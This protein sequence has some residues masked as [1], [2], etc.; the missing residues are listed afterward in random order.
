MAPSGAP[1]SRG[2]VSEARGQ[3]KV[4]SEVRRLVDEWRGFELGRASE[5]YP[6][7]PPRYD[8]VKEGESRLTE[9]TLSLLLHWFRHEPHMVG[10][11]PNTFAFKY[12]PH[13][14]RLVETF[15]YLHEVRGIRRTE[16][17]YQLAGVDPM[18]PQRDPWAKLGGQLAT[19]SGKTKMMSL[20]IAWAYLNAVGERDS[21]LGFG[22]H[23]ILIAPGLFV[24]DRLLMDFAP[25]NK[26]PSVFFADPV[27]PP[28]F[29]SVWNLK[30]YSPETCPRTLDPAEGAL[31]VTNYHQLLRK[32]EDMVEART[33]SPEQRQ[34]GLLFELGEPDKLEAVD[35]PLMDRF[36]RSRGLLVLNDEAHHVWD[37]T[38]H[39]KFEQ[40]AKDKAKVA[41]DADAETAMAWIRCIRRLNGDEKVEGRVALQADLSATLFEEQGAKQKGGKTEFKQTDPF[42]HTAVYYP[43][44]EAITD[45]IVKKPILERVEARN[46][47]TGEPLPPVNMAAPNAWDKYKH[48]LVT[49]IERWKKVRDQLADEGDPRKPILFL[50]CID[51]KEAREVA[52]YLTYG[53]A[54]PDDLSDQK[55]K[56]YH[57]PEAEGPLFLGENGEST[58]VEIH[59]GQKEQSSE[60]AW[61]KV[62]QSVNAIDLDEIPDPERTDDQGHPLMLPNPYNVVVSVMMLKEGWDVRNVKVIVPLRPC[63]S[64]TL[65]EQTLGR[66]LR[67]MHAPILDDDGA[68]ELRSE[69]LLRYRAPVIPGHHRT[70]P[71]RRGLEVER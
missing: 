67:K 36:S 22:R 40:K 4:I 8:V 42:R 61:E 48:L 51:R 37:E 43:L 45:G 38:G 26:R 71:R 7:D 56:G 66:G 9:T 33:L 46:K 17:L 54:V 49:G 6:N 2:T 28:E 47:K 31:V 20:I 50:L 1:P 53:Q 23:S 24:R 15:I 32:R 18:G 35:T 16:E 13:Q 3:W 14:R 64:R 21:S 63:D 70:H 68:A 11:P 5:P 52:N 29:E 30:V 59:I 10:S 19:G 27:I 12:W 44:T 34:L 65:T 60:D 41:G 25:A 58:V 39:A 69:D 55:A 57:D 62:R